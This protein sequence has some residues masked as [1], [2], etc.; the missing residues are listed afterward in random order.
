ML[1]HVE[2]PPTKIR[3]MGEGA[4]LVLEDLRK[5]YPNLMVLCDDDNEEEGYVD[6]E[7]TEWWKSE[8]AALTPGESLRIYRRNAKM[9]LTEVSRRSGIPKGHL[10]A[11]EHG[12]RPMGRIIARKLASAVGCDYRS[13]L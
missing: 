10:S 1:V 4:V 13:L 12:K 8:G 11:M 7:D 3:L 2:K 6:I 9:T 5:L